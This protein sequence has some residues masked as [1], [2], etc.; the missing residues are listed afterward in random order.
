MQLLLTSRCFNGGI[1]ICAGTVL[2]LAMIFFAHQ[3]L[4]VTL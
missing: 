1:D 4:T 2:T 3:R